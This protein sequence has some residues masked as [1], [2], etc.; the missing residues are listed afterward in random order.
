MKNYLQVCYKTLHNIYKNGAYTNI[1]INKQ[2]N[3][4]KD[5]KAI[6]TKVVYG[7]IEN[8]IK[9]DYI[10]SSLAPFTRLHA[11]DDTYIC[12]ERLC[13]NSSRIFFVITP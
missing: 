9:L 12:C 2:L 1:E 6:I 7:T 10:I 13:S 11:S 3:N 5:N 8:D 4:V